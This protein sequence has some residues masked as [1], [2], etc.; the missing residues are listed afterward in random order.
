MGLL[1]WERDRDKKKAIRAFKT[2]LDASP[3]MP[4]LQMSLDRITEI[5]KA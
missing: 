4:L 5:E 1:L 2:S 3:Y